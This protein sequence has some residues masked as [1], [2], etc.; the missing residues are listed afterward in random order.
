MKGA[1]IKATCKEVKCS[2]AGLDQWATQDFSSLADEA[3]D[4]M[5]LMFNHIE[6]GASWPEPTLHAK[7]SYLLKN[8]DD[9][10]DPLGYRVLF[11]MSVPYRR[12]ATT[13]LRQ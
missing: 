5:A 3:Y 11:V 6:A 4:W 12:W 10:G 9:K 2:A 13:R 8:P 7:G 1:D